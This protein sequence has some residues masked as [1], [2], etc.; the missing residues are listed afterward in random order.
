MAAS[1]SAIGAQFELKDGFLFLRGRGGQRCGD[2][3]D[4]GDGND[5][6]QQV[7][8]LASTEKLL[9][10]L[11]YAPP[12]E[13][14]QNDAASEVGTKTVLRENGLPFP[15]K[16]QATRGPASAAAGGGE[17]EDEM[18]IV[19]GRSESKDEEDD[20]RKQEEEG[21]GTADSATPAAGPYSV[22]VSDFKEAHWNDMGY[23]DFGAEPEQEQDDDKLDI[24]SPG[25]Q[26]AVDAADSHVIL[27]DD[28]VAAGT[29][30]SAAEALK[31]YEEKAPETHSQFQNLRRAENLT[32]LLWQVYDDLVHFRQREGSASDKGGGGGSD[33]KQRHMKRDNVKNRALEVQREKLRKQQK[34]Q[35]DAEGL[36]DGNGDDQDDGLEERSEEEG[37]ILI[38]RVL[39]SIRVLTPILLR[40]FRHDLAADTQLRIGKKR[41]NVRGGCREQ[42]WLLSEF[43]Y[44]VTGTRSFKRLSEY[45]THVI[46][47]VAGV[48]E[49][50]LGL[51][52]IWIGCIDKAMHDFMSGQQLS[53]RDVNPRWVG[54]HP[55]DSLPEGT[56]RNAVA[57]LAKRLDVKFCL[58]TDV[59]Q[60]EE[61]HDKYLQSIEKLRSVAETSIRQIY[62]DARVSLYGSCLSDLSLGK[63]AD[64]DMSLH[65]PSVA[66][67]KAK[68]EAGDIQA[69]RYRRTVVDTIH[70]IKRKLL[71]LRHAQFYEVEAITQARVPVLKGRFRNAGNPHSDNGSLHFDICLLNDIAVCNSSLLREYSLVD[72][73]V[74]SLMIAVKRWTSD[75]GIKSAADSCL[76]SYTWMNLVVFYLQCIGFVPNLQCA[77]L[78]NAVGFEPDPSLDW[79]SVNSL[80]TAYLQWS[81]AKGAFAMPDTLQKVSVTELLYGFLNFYVSDFPSLLYMISIKRGPNS[82]LPKTMF[83]KC[84]IFLC[85]EDPFETYD[86]HCPH[87]LG[88][89]ARDSG[90]Q[91]TLACFRAAAGH[92]RNV[93]S[94]PDDDE[95]VD[96]L[97]P[98]P[99]DTSEGQPKGRRRKPANTGAGQTTAGGKGERRNGQ[100]SKGKAG[101][102]RGAPVHAAGKT[103]EARMSNGQGLHVQKGGPNAV[104]K[105]ERGESSKATKS[106]QKHA[107][108]SKGG[109]AGAETLGA[110]HAGT[111]KDRQHGSVNVESQRKGGSGRGGRPR[112]GRGRR[113]GRGG[114]GGGADPAETGTKSEGDEKS[115]RSGGR[116]GGRGGSKGRGGRGGRRGGRSDGGNKRRN[117]GKQTARTE[118][119]A[120]KVGPSDKG[121][122][123]QGQPS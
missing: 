34:Q 50:G 116:N 27:I 71:S 45:Y 59:S 63:N 49:E 41:L 28:V 65:I 99:L 118:D 21:E 2:D 8:L 89:H 70:S 47:A 25:E 106:S 96:E 122:A 7:P 44:D 91:K 22:S 57:S 98:E 6:E 35:D 17:S 5:D 112:S 80:K 117:G 20:E 29:S 66:E 14:P 38:A 39:N 72:P 43:A 36:P 74:R 76:S 51:D 11:G 3:D 67:C 95:Y 62:P 31:A 85:I 73:R 93:L 15:N 108:K 87:N 114:R 60:D 42:C 90:T 105:E 4:E 107:K 30:S 54:L 92:L 52:S 119:S 19:F 12:C 102:K 32:N 120:S 16:R 88:H 75:N 86:S 78:M 109:A 68:F 58:G 115:G 64:V 84:S 103:A 82:L 1:P 121:A 94:S 37:W 9:L 10:R 23:V 69:N 104:A 24:V 48:P 113:G 123:P 111:D 40:M 33:K 81:Q 110:S 18:E 77:D 97:W 83:H 53:G 61:L 26:G 56:D 46:L 100:K 79:H 55:L 13:P 101:G